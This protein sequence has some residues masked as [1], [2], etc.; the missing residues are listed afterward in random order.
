MAGRNMFGLIFTNFQDGY[1][2]S[3]TT[4]RTFSSIP[5]GAKYRLIDFPL[6]NMVNSGI[7]KIGV[8]TKN[9]YLSLMD[10]I[11]S[12][13]SYNL[14]RRRGG[15]T[16]LPPFESTGEK[17]NNFV[18]T[19]DSV[20]DFIKNSYEDYVLLSGSM[21]VVNFDY[22]QMFNAHLK[23]GADLTIC[24]RNMPMPKHADDN[25]VFSIDNNKR[26]SE[27]L[28]NPRS[29]E[30]GDCM[31]KCALVKKDLLLDFVADCISRNKIDF[32]RD[33]VQACIRDYKVY[34][35]EVKGYYS[36]VDTIK[37]Y[38]EANMDLLNADVRSQLFDMRNPI[39]TKVR[40]DMPTKYG[41]HSSVRNSLISPGCVVEGEV[42]N[43]IIFKGVRIEAG[44]KISNCIIMQD[45]V[46]GADT[47][48][49][50]VVCDKDSIITPGRM[51]CGIDSY[52]VCISKKSI[53]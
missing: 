51:L 15:L 26:I 53:V 45:C 6:S 37:S 24:Y 42:E 30:S 10:H 38:F 14:S 8:I 33:V 13:K 44:A 21:S 35:Y 25:I 4:M 5:F 34:G 49:N 36:C 19:I 16:F 9:N 52:P 47:T 39:Y 11:G 12:G 1:I 17:Y 2:P 22:Q 18:Q 31:I 23:S 48:L 20:Q 41:L 29:V 3:L 46:V 50:Y 28:I 7:T 27:V 32:E 40:D 43:S